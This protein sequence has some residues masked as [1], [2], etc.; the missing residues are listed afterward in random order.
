[1]QTDIIER[2]TVCERV[3]GNMGSVKRVVIEYCRASAC[4]VQESIDHHRANGGSES[5]I[6]LIKRAHC[7]RCDIWKIRKWME[8]HGLEIVAPVEDDDDKTTVY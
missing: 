7:V 1:M 3:R 2:E 8:G 4:P 5:E 6:S